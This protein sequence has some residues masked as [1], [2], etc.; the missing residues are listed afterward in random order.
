MKSILIKSLIGTFLIGIVSAQSSVSGTVTD[1]NGNP[2]PGANVVVDGTSIGAATG[3]NGE[4]RIVVPGGTVGGST[5]TLTA[6]FIG[7]KSQSAQV[8]VPMS[9]SVTQNFSLVVRCYRF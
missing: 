6:S 9:G 7:H 4:Y 3:S 1:A 5:A 2:L 8:D